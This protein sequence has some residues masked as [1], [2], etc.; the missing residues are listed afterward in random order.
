MRKP[1][2]REGPFAEYMQANYERSNSRQLEE[3]E[4]ATLQDMIDRSN[5]TYCNELIPKLYQIEPIR[6]GL[7]SISFEGHTTTEEAL[8]WMEKRNMLPMNVTELF[9]FLSSKRKWSTQWLLA[10]GSKAYFGSLDR[11]V[12]AYQNGADRRV[13]LGW[14][15]Q[16][17]HDCFSFGYV[18]PAIPYN[19]DFD[20]D[21]ISSYAN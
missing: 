4:Q 7:Y 6:G 12:A 21:T 2:V 18:D 10:L 1:L 15:D 13:S 20:P 5:L 14:I 16:H 8:D 17:W 3:P 11:S 19:P 9:A